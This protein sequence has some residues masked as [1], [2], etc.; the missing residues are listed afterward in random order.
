MSLSTLIHWGEFEDFVRR[1]Y[2]S[3]GTVVSERNITVVGKSGAKRQIDVRVTFQTP[4]H[5][6]VTIAECKR[7]KE[8]VGRDRIDV[9]AATIEDTNA[10]KG[11]MFTTTGYEEGAIQYAKSKNIDL[12]LIR[13]LT[14]EEWGLPGRHILC[15]SQ[16]VAA[17]MDRL[18]WPD[19]TLTPVVPGW[20]PQLSI[21]DIDGQ[22]D[23]STP[24]YAPDGSTGPTLLKMVRALK[25]S[26]MNIVGQQVPLLDGGNDNASA[27]YQTDVTGILVPECI[28]RELRFPDGTLR[29]DKMRATVW[30]RVLQNKYE[31]DRGEK[32]DLAV[33]LEDYVNTRHKIALQAAG[34]DKVDLADLKMPTDDDKTKALVNGTIFKVFTNTTFE[35]EEGCVVWT[36][37]PLTIHLLPK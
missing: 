12:F 7:W 21:E 24:L 37:S 2:G 6:Y 23:T 15:Y 31:R 1:M 18:E 33:V 27:T 35:I 8:P 25:E 17:R 3:D 22:P 28:H 13:D 4:L 30:T 26:T 5:T 32:V 10:S 36:T 19:A 34:G 29:I 20:V 16:I 11:V 14:D 9:L